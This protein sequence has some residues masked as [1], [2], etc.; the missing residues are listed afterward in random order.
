MVREVL[1]ELVEEFK[2]KMSVTSILELFGIS[3]STYYR[4][5][6]NPSTNEI[7]DYEKLVTQKCIDTKFEYG[8][9][10][11][12]HLLKKDGSPIGINTVQRI[13]QKFDLQYRVKPKRPKPYIG[14][15]SLVANNILDRNFNAGR[16]LEKLV[17]DITY[18]TW[19]S[20]DMYL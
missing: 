7:T 9:R 14:K 3:S 18:F 19:A 4:W 17:I 15:E 13:M 10:T 11:I 8:Y 20:E 6:S 1:V 2:S 12:Y 5:K 16:P